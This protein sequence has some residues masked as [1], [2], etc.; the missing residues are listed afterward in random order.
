MLHYSVVVV[1]Y[2]HWFARSLWRKICLLDFLFSSDGSGFKQTW[3]ISGCV[4]AEVAVLILTLTTE[5]LI[6]FSER[7]ILDMEVGF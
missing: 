7:E 5:V 3:K 2:F 1:K 6:C 4:M